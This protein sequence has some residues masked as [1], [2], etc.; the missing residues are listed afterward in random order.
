[1]KKGCE[2]GAFDAALKGTDIGA[3]EGG[4]EGEF[5]LGNVSSFSDTSEVRAIDYVEPRRCFYTIKYQY[6]HFKHFSDFIYMN[7]QTIVYK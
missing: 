5:F 4:S 1:M 3:V 2:H 6:L 7:L